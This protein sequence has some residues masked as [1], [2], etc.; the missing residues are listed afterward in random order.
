MAEVTTSTV[1]QLIASRE[2]AFKKY[3]DALT[4]YQNVSNELREAVNALGKRGEK[5]NG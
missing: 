3:L 2:E 5:T 4:F 1:H